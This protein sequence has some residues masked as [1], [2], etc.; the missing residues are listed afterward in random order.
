[1]DKSKRTHKPRTDSKFRNR[2][3]IP[4]R[5]SASSKS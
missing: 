2:I 3:Q 5:A 1:M 4:L